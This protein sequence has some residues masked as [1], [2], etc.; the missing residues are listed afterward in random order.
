MPAEDRIRVDRR[1]AWRAL[2]IS[3]AFSP[4]V[5]LINAVSLL[6]DAE[7]RAWRSTRASPGS[8]K[9]PAWL[10]PDRTVPAGRP[11]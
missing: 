11:A 1:V 3:V 6:T 2:L 8:S 5:G 7:R 10:D 4:L 9:S